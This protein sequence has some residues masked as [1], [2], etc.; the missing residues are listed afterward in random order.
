[1]RVAVIIPVWNEVGAIGRVLGELPSGVADQVLV[2]DGGST[3][4][5]QHAASAAGA[6]VLTQ[7]GRGY[8]AACLAGA[9]G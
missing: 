9:R 8:G 1:M 7:Q 2:V 5:T 3:D 4:G 6:M